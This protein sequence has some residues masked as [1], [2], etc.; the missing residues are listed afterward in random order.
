MT[1]LN[2]AFCAAVIFLPFAIPLE[3]VKGPSC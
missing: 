3:R 2:G 1:F